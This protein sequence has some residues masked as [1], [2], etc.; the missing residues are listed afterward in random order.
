MPAPRLLPH[1]L[2]DCLLPNPCLGCGAR[3]ARGDG[4]G[5]CL[6]CQG[7]LRPGH[8]PRCP[9]CGL[10]IPTSASTACRRCRSH[11]PAF[12]RLLY[13]WLFEEPLARVVWALKYRRLDYLAAPWAARLFERV[14]PGFQSPDAVVA[15]PLH[16]RRRLARGFNQAS[17]LAA[18]IAA[19]LGLPLLSMRRIRPTATQTTQS[20]AAR[21]RN[22]RGAFAAPGGLGGRRVLLVDDV[23]TTGATLHAAAT[24]LRA[25]GADSVHAVVLARTSEPGP[26]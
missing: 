24:A 8:G 26:R 1:L 9:S 7:R 3:A 21:R 10:A 13:G 4:L 23:A 22:L 15:V 19:R 12:E 14:A 2:I 6:P 18:P 16:W 5:L 17:L 11:P 25:A 20:A